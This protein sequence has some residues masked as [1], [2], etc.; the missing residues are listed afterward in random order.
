MH[1]Y[2]YRRPATVFVAALAYA[3]VRD[4]GEARMCM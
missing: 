1:M 2:A 3:T 4:V